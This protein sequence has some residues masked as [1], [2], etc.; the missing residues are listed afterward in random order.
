MLA[1]SFKSNLVLEKFIIMA[2]AIKPVMPATTKISINVKPALGEDKF[3]NSFLFFPRFL[4]W[5]KFYFYAVP[6]FY[7]YSVYVLSINLAAVQIK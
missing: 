6:R 1:V 2:E 7:E 5:Y 4:I 3:K